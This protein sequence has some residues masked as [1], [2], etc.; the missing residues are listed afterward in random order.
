M[1]YYLAV[2]IGASSGRHIL[3][4]FIVRPTGLNLC[5]L[6]RRSVILAV[7]PAWLTLPL[8]WQNILV[9]Q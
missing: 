5:S 4:L 2:D 6:R 3:L 8:N 9:N 7:L 1:K